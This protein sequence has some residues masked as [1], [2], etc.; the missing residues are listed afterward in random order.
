[1]VALELWV[2]KWKPRLWYPID[3]VQELVFGGNLRSKVPICQPDLSSSHREECQDHFRCWMW[4]RFAFHW[5]MLA[6]LPLLPSYREMDLGARYKLC[7]EHIVLS[8]YSLCW[9]LSESKLA[10]F[11][12]DSEKLD[13]VVS[14]E[15]WEITRKLSSGSALPGG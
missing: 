1:M 6:N 8:R 2:V 7:H 5:N 14:K 9:M 4:T 10:G 13:L 11:L 15:A 12:Q 3:G